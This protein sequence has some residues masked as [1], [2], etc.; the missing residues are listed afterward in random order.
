VKNT[1]QKIIDQSLHAGAEA[2]DVIVSSA[3]SMNLGALDG[4]LDKFKVS[5]TSLFGVRVIKNKKVGLSYSESFDDDAIAFAAKNAVSNA[6]Y[7]DQ[8]EHETISITNSKDFIGQAPVKDNSST[9]EKIEFAL[10]LESE[11]KKRDSRIQSVPYNGITVSNSS[12]YYLNSLGRYTEESDFA[13]SAYTSSLIKDGD[14]SSMH[15]ASMQ[16][17]DLLKL[18]LEGSIEECLEHSINW[19]TAAPV[20]TGSYDVIFHT[21]VLS[22]LIGSFSSCF[23]AKAAITKT[24]MWENKLNELVAFS[25]FTLIDSPAYEDA[26]YKQYVDAEGAEKVDLTMIEN[27]V[28]KSFYHNT[29][30]ANHF[31]TKTTG[32]ASRGPR[33]SLGVSRSNW[34]ILPGTSSESDMTEGTYLEVVDVMGMGPGT[35]SIS[36][37]F[38]FGASGYL[39]KNGK[40]IQPVKGITIAGNFNK[41]LSGISRMGTEL[42]PNDSAN[43]FSPLIRFSDL[44][45]AGK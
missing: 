33:S 16:G 40:R 23:S 22:S 2:C 39:C 35:N 4:S 21:E 10:K 43:T 20:A 6:D 3:E 15:Y 7:S 30:T 37:E 8:S 11:I 41:L 1:L 14:V 25:N 5:K 9:E 38:S 19:L 18:D 17:R 12:A 13:M 32:H 42:K 31:G 24:N 27:G 26:F 29:A 45:V 34:I 44:S 36:G 28:L